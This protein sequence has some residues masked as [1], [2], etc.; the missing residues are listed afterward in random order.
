V[1]PSDQAPIAAQTPRP[2]GLQILLAV[3]LLAVASL[4]R[5]A[6][7]RESPEHQLFSYAALSVQSKRDSLTV[8]IAP[9]ARIEVKLVMKKGQ[10]AEFVW[11]A[12]GEGVTYN[13]HGDGPDAPGGKPFTYKRG[14]SHGET[15]E[16][17][18]AFDGIHGWA[19]RNLSE[20]PVKVTVTAWG[21]FSELRKL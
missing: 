4:P 15:G 13:M 14:K 21:Q 17:V 19:W 5:T 11:R 18:A 16:I 12:D 3:A 2:V 6:L 20:K 10:K 8:T 9:Y 1:K 7:A